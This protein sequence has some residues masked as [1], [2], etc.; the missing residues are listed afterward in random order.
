MQ[1]QQLHELDLE[2]LQFVGESLKLLRQEVDGQV[3]GLGDHHMSF[4]DGT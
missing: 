2:Q 1:V 3:G 4:N